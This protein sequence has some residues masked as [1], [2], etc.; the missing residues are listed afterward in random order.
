M[1]NAQKTLTALLL[2]AA[3]GLLHLL[4]YSGIWFLEM[5]FART[6]QA[7]AA[8]VSVSHVCK[9][10]IVEHNAVGFPFRA[11]Y[12]DECQQDHAPVI[13]IM[14]VNYALQL[15]FLAA[16]FVILQEVF[17]GGKRSRR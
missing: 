7:C 3:F 10:T 4:T 6:R 14:G 9:C 12:N 5:P 1:T 15:L 8:S 2:A 11:N 17:S 13:W 16:V